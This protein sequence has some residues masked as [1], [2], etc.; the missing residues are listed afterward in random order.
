VQVIHQGTRQ[1]FLDIQ[2]DDVIVKRDRGFV[3]ASTDV[4]AFLSGFS[5]NA[6]IVQMQGCQVFVDAASI[7]PALFSV[8]SSGL[9][10]HFHR[11]VLLASCIV[12]ETIF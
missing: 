9:S 8:K 11:R 10:S 3:P 12:K 4:H 6:D 1:T 5:G 7:S 2:L